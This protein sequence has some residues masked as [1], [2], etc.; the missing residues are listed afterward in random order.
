MADQSQIDLVKVNLPDD[1]D[2]NWSDIAIG[3]LL[4]SGLSITKVTLSFWASRVA[5]YSSLVD[6]SESGSSRSLS[7]LF[8]Q[9]KT[10]YDMWFEKSKAEDDLASGVSRHRV[11]FHKAKRV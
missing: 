11:A 2:E 8:S 5:K 9:A 1:L 3:A 10:A 6:V 4:D 7:A